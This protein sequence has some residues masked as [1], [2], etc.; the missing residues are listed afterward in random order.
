MFWQGPESSFRAASPSDRRRWPTAPEAGPRKRRA[1]RRAERHRDGRHLAATQNE[2]RAAPRGVEAPDEAKPLAFGGLAAQ[3]VDHAPPPVLAR[4]HADV[5]R[6]A[7]ERRAGEER[8][9]RGLN[10][11]SIAG[12]R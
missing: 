11:T 5:A 6:P 10:V 8:D 4:P 3:A 7:D 12:R 9:D 1:L 2:D